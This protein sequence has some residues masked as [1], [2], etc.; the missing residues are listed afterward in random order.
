MLLLD[1]AVTDLVCAL[2]SCVTIEVALESC[3]LYVGK[4][5]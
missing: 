1:L 3:A 2:I 5:V 4:K